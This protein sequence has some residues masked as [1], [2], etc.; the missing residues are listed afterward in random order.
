MSKFEI[1]HFSTCV[2]HAVYIERERERQT[3]TKRDRQTDKQTFTKRERMS[4]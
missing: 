2:I 1:L 3:V 4:N